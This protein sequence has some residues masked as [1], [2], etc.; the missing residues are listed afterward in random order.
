MIS[1]C[2]TSI[3]LVCFFILI[4]IVVASLEIYKM[5]SAKHLSDG[6]RPSSAVTSAG[7]AI[8]IQPSQNDNKKQR[9]CCSS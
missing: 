3:V 8:T 7:N 5:V 1:L 6:G 4:I 9:S 2:E